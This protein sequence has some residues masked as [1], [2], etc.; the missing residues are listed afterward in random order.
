MVGG[1]VFHGGKREGKKIPGAMGLIRAA[2]CANRG[3]MSSTLFD[4]AA[5]RTGKTWKTYMVALCILQLTLMI[6]A[7]SGFSFLREGGEIDLAG[8]KIVR[9]ALSATYGI[10]FAVFIGTAYFESGL[11][12]RS[13]G[14]TSG[15]I[16]AKPAAIDLWF[17]S[18][19]SH[20]RFMRGLFWAALGYGFF[21]LGFF[22]WVHVAGWGPP[23]YMPFWA[24]RAIGV[25]DLLVLIVCLE[26]ARRI[27]RNFAEVKS[28]LGSP[29][30]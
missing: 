24:Y 22:G 16:L 20:S 28:K 6:D 7:M 21:L 14:D 23:K 19:F 29:A 17:I 15:S 10:L 27:R 13:A 4:A 1:M 9:E 25:V 30:E 8:F 18:P 11:L 26:Y 5:E 2:E 3:T 12:L